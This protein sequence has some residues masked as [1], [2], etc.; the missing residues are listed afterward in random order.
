MKV[1]LLVLFFSMCFAATGQQSVQFDTTAIQ[2]RSFNK[3]AVAYKL[4]AANNAINSGDSSAFNITN[5]SASNL[6]FLIFNA[7]AVLNCRGR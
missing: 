1:R 5:G 6:Q 3:S 7:V 4:L 2:P